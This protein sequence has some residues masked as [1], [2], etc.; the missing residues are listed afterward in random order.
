MAAKVTS[1]GP[2]KLGG[3]FAKSTFSR[4]D[5]KTIT[6]NKYLRDRKEKEAIELNCPS[7]VF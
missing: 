6:L 7:S 2:L 3:I 5:L 4:N 1:E